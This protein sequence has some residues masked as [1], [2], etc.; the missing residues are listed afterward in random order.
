MLSVGSDM[1]ESYH[2]LPCD[3][4]FIDEDMARDHQNSTGHQVIERKLEK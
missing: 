1:K 4:A 3:K 2:C